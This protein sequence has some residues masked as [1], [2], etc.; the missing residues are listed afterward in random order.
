LGKYKET[1]NALL[2]TFQNMLLIDEEENKLE[3]C[4]KIIGF[5]LIELDSNSI[6][7]N[8]LNNKGLIIPIN[9]KNIILNKIN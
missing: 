6:I 3:L 2:I 8:I 5:W 7:N 9:I 4:S 1:E